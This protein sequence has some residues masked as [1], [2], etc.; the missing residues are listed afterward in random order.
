MPQSQLNTKGQNYWNTK[1]KF[2]LVFKKYV[3]EHIIA[4]NLGIYFYSKTVKKI[5]GIW[6]Y[7]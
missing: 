6:I 3:F 4:V 2:G 1:E 7:I 5:I